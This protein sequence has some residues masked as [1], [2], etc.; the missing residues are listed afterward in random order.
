[1][2]TLT[3][4]CVFLAVLLAS[5]LLVGQDSTSKASTADSQ[6]QKPARPKR[7]T[8][9]AKA[10]ETEGQQFL[11][12]KHD[13]ESAIQSFKKSIKLDPWYGQGYLMLG[14]AYTQAERWDDAQWAFQEVTKLEPENLRAWLGVGSAMNE[15]KDYAHAQKALEHCLDLK[16]DSAEAHYE[17]G[18]TLLGL[19]KLPEAEGEARRAIELN[20]DYVSPH[21]LL[22]NI[23]VAEYDPNSAITEFREALRL[24][25]EGPQA[26]AIKENISMLEKAIAEAE[27]SKKH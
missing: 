4:T 21:L 17:M 2:R 26:P 5:P 14:V 3:P 9:A 24:D 16:S 12:Q 7:L 20:N 18:R 10:A 23:Y 19:G 13:I 1:M 11:F 22:A 6:E 25:P 8:D 15:Q 27:Q